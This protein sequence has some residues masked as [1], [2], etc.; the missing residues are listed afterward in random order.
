MVRALDAFETQLQS[1]VM[2]G[3]ISGHRKRGQHRG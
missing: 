2:D 1:F 3:K